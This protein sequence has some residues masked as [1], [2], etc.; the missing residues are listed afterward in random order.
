MLT[1]IYDLYSRLWKRVRKRSLL[2][3]DMYPGDIAL[4]KM[5][6]QRLLHNPVPL[7]AGGVLTARRF[8][9]VGLGYLGSSPSAFAELHQL[10]SSAFV[11][12]PSGNDSDQA[13]IMEEIPKLQFQR[14][15]LK[16][17]EIDQSFDD[18]PIYFWLHESIYADGEANAPTKWA[19]HRSYEDL[20]KSYPGV[21]DYRQT[22]GD[23]D[24]DEVPTLFFGEMVFP[25]MADGDY[26]ELSG[27]GLRGVAEA[28]ANK[29]DWSQLF[30]TTMIS[31][32]LENGT[33]RAAAAT[34]YDDLYVDFDASMEVLDGPMK[35]VK[36][37]VTNEYQHS[38]LRDDGATIFQK[39]HGM[40]TGA[41]RIPS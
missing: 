2:Y 37:H 34:Y 6:V 8:L 9:Q 10:L 40:A 16:E 41:I 5:I 7:P 31:Q 26:A 39:L 18:A 32:A 21:W 28:L 35:R 38:G 27:F 3:Y 1:P 22:S 14:S 25:W 23:L 13:N 15:F 24:K 12:A 4:V 17:I 30:N 29:N 36:V 20:V 33:S 19:A 11:V